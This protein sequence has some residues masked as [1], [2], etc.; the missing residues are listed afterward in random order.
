MLIGSVNNPMRPDSLRKVPTPQQTLYNRRDGTASP[1][2]LV[3][4]RSGNDDQ[5]RLCEYKVSTS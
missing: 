4:W 2:A 5:V 1:Q 3:E